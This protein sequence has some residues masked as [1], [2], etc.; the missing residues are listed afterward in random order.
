MSLKLYEISAKLQSLWATV[1]AYAEGH[2][3]EMPPRASE[4]IDAL[5]LAREEKVLNIARIIKNYQA[6]SDALEAESKRLR[7]KKATAEAQI[8]YLK[9]YLKTNL[10]EG[11]KITDGVLTVSWK[12]NPPK[13]VVPDDTKVPDQ[14]CTFT[15]TVSKT[16][17]SEFLKGGGECEFA[18]LVQEQTIQ[19]R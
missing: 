13:V 6:E 17:L 5:E 15:R 1:E 4:D 14:F 11:Q 10:S 7:A 16:E 8:D 2:N 9:N 19:I 12:K 3:G 18:S